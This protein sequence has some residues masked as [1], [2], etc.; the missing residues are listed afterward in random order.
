M[1]LKILSA[2]MSVLFVNVYAYAQEIETY[3]NHVT[4]KTYDFEIRVS[5]VSLL[6]GW[7]GME[8][9]YRF[10]DQLDVGINGTSYQNSVDKGGNMFIP[11][12]EGHS[13]GLNMN[14]YFSSATNGVP[15][16][17]ASFKLNQDDFD[18]IGHA[19]STITKKRGMSSSGLLGYRAPIQILSKQFSFLVAGGMQTTFY[20]IEERNKEAPQRI[21]QKTAQNNVVPYVEL[22]IAY[23]F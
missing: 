2:A 3:A 8:L 21:T 6:F 11:T 16:W 1:K 20:S 9:A 7:Y 18:S 23:Q 12:Y 19:S 5:P 14:Y 10:N 17:Y 4:D 13:V 22:K 15:T